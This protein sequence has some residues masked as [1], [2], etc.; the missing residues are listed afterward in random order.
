[1]AM[2]KLVL[3]AVA[4]LLLAIG[5][6]HADHQAYYQCGK[7]VIFVNMGKGFTD[8]EL[9]TDEKKDRRL[10]GRF[11]RWSNYNGVL[12]YRGRKCQWREWP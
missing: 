8:Y 10:P 1:M 6:A 11:F 5:A 7:D 12:Y 4:A 9:V 3:A 2:N